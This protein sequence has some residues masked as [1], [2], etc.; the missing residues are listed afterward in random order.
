ML[1]SQGFTDEPVGGC[2]AGDALTDGGLDAQ[3]IGKIVQS[4]MAE[5]KNRGMA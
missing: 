5:L 1:A 3:E 2:R 4:V